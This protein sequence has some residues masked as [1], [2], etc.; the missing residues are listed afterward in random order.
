MRRPR[1]R[2]DCDGGFLAEEPPIGLF[3]GPGWQ[4]HCLGPFG[5]EPRPNRKIGGSP[6]IPRGPT[7]VQAQLGD[8]EAL[9]PQKLR[10]GE[11][12]ALLPRRGVSDEQQSAHHPCPGWECEVP[13]NVAGEYATCGT[14]KCVRARGEFGPALPSRASKIPFPRS[15]PSGECLPP[16]A[17]RSPGVEGNGWANLGYPRATARVVRLAPPPLPLG[18][19]SLTPTSEGGGGAQVRKWGWPRF[20]PRSA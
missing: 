6:Y 4:R 3:P 9:V 2:G 16:P 20:S 7:P 8:N 11:S 18:F 17:R 1:P 13:A 15:I 12:A 5:Q 19:A 14:M 10:P